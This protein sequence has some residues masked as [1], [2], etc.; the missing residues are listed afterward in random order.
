MWH[1]TENDSSF[2]EWNRQNG[3]SLIL[4]IAGMTDWQA[5]D[6][7]EACVDSMHGI[8]KSLVSLHTKTI[9]IKYNK[10]E[11]TRDQ[12]C[13]KLEEIGYIPN[14]IVSDLNENNREINHFTDVLFDQFLL[15]SN[16]ETR[17]NTKFW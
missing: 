2:E 15:N 4:H 8:E 6:E 11:I 12:I 9:N 14:M 1:D 3:F 13:D 7:V 16:F 17:I 10:M 5:C